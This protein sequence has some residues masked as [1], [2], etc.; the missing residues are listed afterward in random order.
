[1]ICAITVLCIIYTGCGFVR[2]A[3]VPVY[4]LLGGILVQRYRKLKYD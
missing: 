1:M 4:T 3:I 2:N